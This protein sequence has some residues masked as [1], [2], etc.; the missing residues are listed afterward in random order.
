MKFST[1]PYKG[2]FNFFSIED[3]KK[4]LKG[5]FTYKGYVKNTK[6][7]S[8]FGHNKADYLAQIPLFGLVFCFTI[9]LL[10]I[11][12]VVPSIFIQQLRDK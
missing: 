7:D 8:K 6:P 4:N 9:D 3:V 1:E 12:F 2:L 10:I 11:V 5:Y